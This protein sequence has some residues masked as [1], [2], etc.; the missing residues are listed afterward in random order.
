MDNVDDDNLLAD[1]DL[2]AWE[3]PPP[4]AGLADAVVRRARE[5]VP[6]AISQPRSLKPWL[7]G[8]GALAALVAALAIILW[9]IQ[10]APADGSGVVAAMGPRTLDLGRSSAEVDS[11]TQLT[12]TRRG[13]NLSIAQSRGAAT[14]RVSDEDKAVIDATLASIEATG[15]S[16]RVEVEMMNRSDVRSMGVGSAAAIVVSLV[17]VIV[18]E[19]H[20]KATSNGQT[21]NIQPGASMQFGKPAPTP[22][23]LNVGGTPEDQARIRELE[24]EVAK[25]KLELAARD[26]AKDPPKDPPKDNKT[27]ASCDEVSCVLNNYDGS[28]CQKFKKKAPACDMD[29]F[30]TKGDD[31]LANGM[32][33]AALAQFE[34]SLACA[35]DLT[36]TKKAFIAACRS[37]NEAKAR[38]FA[39]DVPVAQ[40]SNY[41]QICLRY[42]IT[43]DGIDAPTCDADAFKKKGDE[44]LGNGMDTA[45]LAAFE[46]SL[47]CKYDGGVVKTAFLA[48]CRSKQTAKAK[49]YFAKLPPNMA[50]NYSQICERFGIDVRGDYTPSSTTGTLKLNSKPVARVQIDGATAGTTPLTTKLTPGKH[51]VTFIVD[52]GNKYTFPVH[53]KANEVTSLIKDFEVDAP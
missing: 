5:P 43:L 23:Q 52:G 50:A 38:K 39:A 36:V 51:K 31:Y 19:G 16:L 44:Y 24:A 8:G 1:Y 53:V 46:A 40:R 27:S 22:E 42:G 37:K 2:S 26:K 49:L 48:A 13:A 15:A 4:T 47:R 17:T 41:T 12:W 33:V 14:W 28:C 25:L 35:P 45:A 11:G 20:V 6:R 32:D 18:Y 3:V 29:A 21:V 10:R 30:N 34:K 9:G 7:V